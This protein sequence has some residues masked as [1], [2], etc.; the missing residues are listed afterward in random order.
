MKESK[1]AQQ[2]VG[3]ALVAIAPLCWSTS[4]LFVRTIEADL[5]TMLF[6]RG[7]FSGAGILA[8]L[9]WRDRG[10]VWTKFKAL[11]WPG[12]GVAAASAGSMVAGN[13]SLRFTS[14]AASLSIYATL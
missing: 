8:F 9:V 13:A 3:L 11:S 12:L 14:V 2:R 10:E 4:G 6:W 5:P 7:I 1:P